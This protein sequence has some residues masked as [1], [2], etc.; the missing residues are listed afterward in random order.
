MPSPTEKLLSSLFIY[1]HPLYRAIEA[2]SLSPLSE[3]QITSILSDPIS[4][5]IFIDMGNC[6][7]AFDGRDD[8][9]DAGKVFKSFHRFIVGD[10][11]I[12]CPSCVPQP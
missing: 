9:F 5:L 6:M 4:E 1:L 11:N 7:G 12:F 3:R 10:R 8:P 2:T